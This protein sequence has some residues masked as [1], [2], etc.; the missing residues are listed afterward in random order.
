MTISTPQRVWNCADFDCCTLLMRPLLRLSSR[1]SGS[2]TSSGGGCGGVR[3]NL[4]RPVSNLTST[5]LRVGVQS[6]HAFCTVEYIRVTKWLPPISGWPA[7]GGV[8]NRAV[9]LI[10]YQ[11]LKDPCQ[12]NS[13]LQWSL[14]CYV[15]CLLKA[16]MNEI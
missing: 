6:F 12:K 5:L 7:V 1:Q 13:Y 16:R 8:E 15:A 2:G 10:T 11:H 9:Q 4:G 14:F 3:F